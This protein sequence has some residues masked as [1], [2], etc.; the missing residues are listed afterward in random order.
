MTQAV[1]RVRITQKDIEKAREELTQAPPVI[2]SRPKEREKPQ[3]KKAYWYG[4][5][6]CDSDGYASILDGDLEGVWLG[7]TDEFIPYLRSKGIDGGNMG[8]VFQAAKEFH[9]EHEGLKQGHRPPQ[10]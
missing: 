6:Y 3:Y 8:L 2:P 10:K 1:K 9:S 7:K 4:E 5:I